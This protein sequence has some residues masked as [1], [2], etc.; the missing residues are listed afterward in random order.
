[1]SFALAPAA[2]LAL[3]ASLPRAN[4]EQVCDVNAFGEQRC[5]DESPMSQNARLITGL[6]IMGLG[7]MFIVLYSCLR[8]R[9]RKMAAKFASAPS[10]SYYASQAQG[11][12][13]GYWQGQSVGATIPATYDP[14]APPPPHQQPYRPPG[15][16]AYGG[17]GQDMGGT[18]MNPPPQYPAATYAPPY[19]APSEKEKEYV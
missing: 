17:Y 19:G 15:Y 3:I 5:H 9:R 14:N 12:G 1:M 8:M 10:T 4:A 11:Q 13:Q 16:N 18:P 2:V 6:V 7:I